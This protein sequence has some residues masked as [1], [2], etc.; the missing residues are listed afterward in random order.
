MV[1]ISKQQLVLGQTILLIKKSTSIVSRTKSIKREKK[2]IIQMSAL[3]TVLR[4]IRQTRL[5]R[6]QTK[7][8]LDAFLQSSQMSVKTGITVIASVLYI[9]RNVSPV[10]YL[11]V[12]ILLMTLILTG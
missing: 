8:Y 3:L 2:S 7:L 1:L 4:V 11:S 10:A 6:W 12:K 9:N 5:D